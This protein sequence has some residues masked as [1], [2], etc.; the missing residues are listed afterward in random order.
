MT[1]L[2]APRLRCS[3]TEIFSA[4]REVLPLE[5]EIRA[6]EEREDSLAEDPAMDVD[7]L[8]EMNPPPWFEAWIESKRSRWRCATRRVD[9]LLTQDLKRRRRLV[10]DLLSWSV[11]EESAVRDLCAMLANEIGSGP[12]VISVGSGAG[13]WERLLELNGVHV[14][15]TDAQPPANTWIECSKQE[16]SAAVRANPTADCLM[17]VWPPAWETC[18]L[19]ALEVF[20]GDYVIYVGEGIDGCT[21]D[22]AY[23]KL[24][25]DGSWT[26][27][28]HRQIP[29][30]YGAYDFLS[31]HKRKR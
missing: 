13:L 2:S 1:P 27:V 3:E 11:P 25:T 21:D 24:A 18:A 6:A 31:L 5:S 7:A 9:D 8:R 12:L 26:E 4:L 22:G 30:Y 14:I 19:S 15:A 20:H 17:T 16:A 10:R 29:R 28:L 23:T